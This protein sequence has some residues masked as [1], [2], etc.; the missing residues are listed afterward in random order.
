MIKPIPKQSKVNKAFAGGKAFIPFITC[1]DPDL[2]TTEKLV[3]AMEEAG[4]DLIQLGIPFSDQATIT[5][6]IKAANERALSNNV[7]VDDIFDMV[8]RIRK[9]SNVP[10]A[11]M[12]SSKVVTAYGTAK[13]IAAS[14]ERGIDALILPDVPYE[15]KREYEPVCKRCGID[16]ISLITPGSCEKAKT[17]AEN[18]NGFVFYMP[19]PDVSGQ[20]KTSCVDISGMAK[21]I[22][23]DLPCAASSCIETPE[24][25]KEIAEFTDGVIV[26]SALVH[27]CEKYGRDCV[28][29]VFELVKSMKQ[30]IC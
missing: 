28:P 1:G 18:A 19:R 8:L 23:E 14:A 17:I 24:Q 26:G 25:A 5:P 15:S 6:T 16:F 7:T 12:T 4:A 2:E 22:R 20:F 3:Y 29:Y 10:L 21:Q 27:L 30:A 13:F 9:K 11:F